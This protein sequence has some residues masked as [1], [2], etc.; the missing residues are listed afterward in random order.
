MKMNYVSKIQSNLKRYKTIK[1]NKTTS[2]ILDG[3]YNSVYK[4]RS[5]NFDELREYV[6]GDDIKDMDW[7]ASARGRR[8]LV[9]QYVA[10]KKH[11]IMLVMDTNSKML[12]YANDTQEKAEVALLC[13]GTLAYLVNRNGDYVSST[14]ATENSVSHIPFRTGL[15]NIENIL[16][17]YHKA[18]TAGNKS[19]INKPLEYI[20]HNY[21]RRMIILIVTDIFGISALSESLL[22]QLLVRHDVLLVDVEDADVSGKRVYDVEN[23]NYLPDFF[24]K[25][26]KL[27]DIESKKREELETKCIE[28]LKRFGIAS[29][30]ITDTNEIDSKIIELLEKHKDNVK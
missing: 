6:P 10:E 26:K 8:L 5:M 21:N 2:R 12:A 13:G 14:F 1:T 4:G 15:M 19:D 29:S 28:K 25:D 16:S 11:N 7:K 27:A 23:Q 30:V 18:V 17:S 22:K 3:T 24:T 9:R 20:A